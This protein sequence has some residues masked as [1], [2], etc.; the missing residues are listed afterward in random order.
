M[1]DVRLLILGAGAVVQEYYLPALKELNWL[2]RTLIVDSSE[3]PLRR[4][5]SYFPHARYERSDFKEYLSKVKPGDRSMAIIALPNRLH[6]PAADAALQRGFHVLCEKPLAMSEKECLGLDQRAR[7]SGKVLAVG[8]CRRF[9]PSVYALNEALCTGKLG[10][11][12]SV[13]MEIGEPYSWLSDSGAFFQKENGGVLTDLGVHYLDLAEE[14]AGSL[15]PVRYSD[16]WKGGVEANIDYVLQSVKGISV[17]LKLSRTHRLRNTLI[18]RGTDGEVVLQKDTFDHCLWTSYKDGNVRTLLTRHRDLMDTSLLIGLHRAFGEQI[19]RFEEAIRL[20]QEVAVS[21]SRAATTMR[22][23]EWAYVSRK[24]TTY[25]RPKAAAGGRPA[26][27]PVKTLVTGATGFIGGHLVERLWNLGFREVVAPVRRYR[28]CSRIARFD[29]QMPRANLTNL[30]E[31]RCM[32]K[33]VRYVFHLEYG[34]DG[35]N[36]QRVTVQ[37]TMNVVNAALKAG[38]ETIVILSTMYVFGFPEKEVS[39][40]ETHGYHPFGGEYGRSKTEMERWCLRRASRSKGTRIVVLN[41]TCVYGPWGSTYSELPRRLALEGRF[42]WVEEGRG[43]ANYTYVD[44]LIDAMILAAACREAHGERFIINDGTCSWR[45]FLS[46]FLDSVSVPSR[47]VSE[48]IS[49]AYRLRSS[50]KEILLA[51]PALGKL[52]CTVDVLRNRLCV[53]NKAVSTTAPSP[54]AWLAELFGPT[55]TRFSSAKAQQILGWWPRIG[56]RE[57]QER[58]KV[59]LDTLETQG[60]IPNGLPVLV[61]QNPFP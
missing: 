10:T 30:K 49:P 60:K 20:R 22:L 48:L 57:G 56:L 14:L 35:F 55:S 47:K 11:L 46:P 9:L 24:K 34:R 17:R 61:S 43:V 44:N 39:V 53:A 5:K 6:V 50:L 15:K 18:F 25:Q 7:E 13:D 51:V 2:D 41:P 19:L 23:I 58:T 29:I 33:G 36:R 38:V 40:D 8:M 4:A 3:P 37:G 42:C 27:A 32:M 21:A 52:K 12:L 54:P 26:L 1:S 28:R 59:W 31:C 45:D 16:D